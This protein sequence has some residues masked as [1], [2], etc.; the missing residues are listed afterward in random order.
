MD[1]L[2]AI[3]VIALFSTADFSAGYLAA[4]LLVF[5]LLVAMILWDASC[6]S[7]SICSGRALMWFLMLQSGVHATIAGVL[8]AFAI[9][10]PPRR[11]NAHSPSHRLEHLLHTPVAFII[12]PTRTA[13]QEQMMSPTSK[14]PSAPSSQAHATAEPSLRHQSESL[15]EGLRE[16]FPASDPVAVS[17][18]C[19]VPAPTAGSKHAPPHGH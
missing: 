9:P 17:I 4:S 5:A 10:F 2:G 8:L 1:D 3:I 15:D 18:T 14:T 16:T 6:R 7:R 12:L 13:S 11:V 19:I